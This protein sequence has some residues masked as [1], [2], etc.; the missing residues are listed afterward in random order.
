[1]KKNNHSDS[2][3]FSRL[4][5]YALPLKKAFITS[6]ILMI[7]SVGLNS[8]IPLVNS[9]MLSILGGKDIDSNL[10]IAFIGVYILLILTL[11]VIS[12]FQSLIL[13]RAGQR[14]IYNI[15]E[16]VYKLVMGDDSFIVFVNKCSIKLKI[17]LMNN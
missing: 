11:I 1:M 2:K 15:R 10:F 6:F 4:I 14:I 12:F 3:I 5:K 17:S 8:I 13:Q 16:Q 9:Q 7:F